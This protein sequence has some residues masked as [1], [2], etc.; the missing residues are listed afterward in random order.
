MLAAAGLQHPDELEPHHLVR[1]VSATEIKQYAQPRRDQRQWISDAARQIGVNV[2]AEGGF[3]LEDLGMIMDRP[4]RHG[5][6]CRTTVGRWFGRAD[7][8]Q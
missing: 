6:R 2:T 8:L 3:F 7:V 5:G 1:R 4:R